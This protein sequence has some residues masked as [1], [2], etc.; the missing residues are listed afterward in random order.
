MQW[1]AALDAVRRRAW[2]GRA[3]GGVTEDTRRLERDMVFV[4]RRGLRTDGHQLLAAARDKGAAFTVGSR[5]VEAGLPDVLVPDSDAA[6]ARLVSA[7]YRDPGHGLVLVGVTGTNGKTTVAHLMAG[8]LKAA[9]FAV[10]TL[11]TLGYAFADDRRPATHTTPPPET[12][13]RVLAGWREAGATHVVAE[14]SA[15]AL[16]QRRVAACRFRAAALTSFARDHGE[17]YADQACYRAAKEQLFREAADVAVLPRDAPD[18]PAFVAA[19]RCPIVTFG[20]GGMVDVHWLGGTLHTSTCRLCLPGLPSK[21]LTLR[22][23]GSY[24]SR[25]AA[26]AA[27]LA[28]ALGVRIDAIAQGLHGAQ[29]PPGRATALGLPERSA[30]AVVDYAHNPAALAATLRWLRGAVNGRLHVV[31]GARGG[32]DADKRPLM[33][34]VIAALADSAVFTADRPAPEDAEEAAAPLLQ[35]ARECGLPARFV[36][37]RSEAIAVAVAALRPGDCLLVTGKGTEPWAP[38]DGGGCRRSG[39]HRSD[40]TLLGELGAVTGDGTRP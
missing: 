10:G 17:Y 28:W 3:L 11:G 36:R 39:E 8:I 37:D 19:A 33:G 16:S 21:H 2:R 5:R 20:R 13:Y 31:L 22:L 27:A 23:P 35:A 32:R 12:L 15:Q 4:A 29:P 9:G 6:L 30:W 18:Y 14:V 34:A 40:L 25:N 24:N 26:C 1:D 7:W 38:G